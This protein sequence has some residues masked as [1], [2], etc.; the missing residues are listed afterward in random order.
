MLCLTQGY[1][2]TFFCILPKVLQFY[3]LHLGLRSIL[4]YFFVYGTRSDF[5]HMDSKCSSTTLKKTNLSSLTCPCTFV[6][7][8]P[9]KYVC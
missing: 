8:V 5:L 2:D 4:S 3:V 6:L 1:K 7:D 9:S